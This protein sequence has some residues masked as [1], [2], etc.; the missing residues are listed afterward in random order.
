MSVQ[1]MTHLQLLPSYG[2]EQFRQLN[3]RPGNETKNGK[4]NYNGINHKFILLGN[5]MIYTI[6]IYICVYPPPSPEKSNVNVLNCR[7]ARPRGD[8]HRRFDCWQPTRQ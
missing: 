8:H 5:S 7:Y 2:K 6:E 3:I 1:K 4:I